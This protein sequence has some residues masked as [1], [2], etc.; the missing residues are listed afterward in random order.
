[1]LREPLS[2][3]PVALADVNSLTSI[4]PSLKTGDIFSLASQLGEDGIESRICIIPFKTASNE[5]GVFTGFRPDFLE[6]EGRGVVPGAVVGISNGRLS[7][8]G[9]FNVIIGSS[10]V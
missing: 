10:M 6:V 8:D 2:G 9:S 4:L 1:M 5:K 3:A 7:E